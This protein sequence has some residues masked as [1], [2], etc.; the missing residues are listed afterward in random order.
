MSLVVRPENLDSGHLALHVT[1]PHYFLFHVSQ[2]R[3]KALTSVHSITVDNFTI[4]A[5]MGSAQQ[6]Q[7]VSLTASLEKYFGWSSIC[8]LVHRALLCATREWHLW[9]LTMIVQTQTD[10]RYSPCTVVSIQDEPLQLGEASFRE[11]R[12]HHIRVNVSLIVSAQIVVRASALKVVFPR[13]PPA[14]CI[15]LCQVG[16]RSEPAN[17]TSESHGLYRYQY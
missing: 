6:S 8:L 9:R 2:E 16:Y 5:K 17:G 12:Q 10:E 7:I 15:L 13:L 11:T 4:W 1:P 3:C 14:L